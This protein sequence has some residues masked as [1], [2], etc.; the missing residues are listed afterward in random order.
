MY[1]REIYSSRARQTRLSLS[2]VT[3]RVLPVFEWDEDNEA[4]LLEA[5]H[6]T[7]YEAESCFLNPHSRKRWRDRFLLLGKTDEDRM[8]FL[9]YVQRP[10]GTIRVISGRDMEPGERRA[11]RRNAR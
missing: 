3:G 6:V 7:A 9:V 1:I 10:D 8:L 11:Y 2:T 5:H 4:H